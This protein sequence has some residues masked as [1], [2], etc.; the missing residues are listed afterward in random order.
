MKFLAPFCIAAAALLLG[1]CATQEV[2]KVVTVAGGRTERIVLTSNGPAH[3]EDDRIT[4]E[5]T[6][7]MP[8]KA[9]EKLAHVYIIKPHTKHTIV[10]VQI[11]DITQD[12]ET[13]L[14][15]TTTPKITQDNFCIGNSEP[16]TSFPIENLAWV[17]HESV[18]TL[19]YRVK[20]TY[21][22]GKTSNLVSA[23]MVPF[24]VKQL[25]KKEL[26]LK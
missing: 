23:F 11:S 8:V 4:V 26:G 21:D 2:I 14:V 9:T 7:I 6:S 12:P 13:V 10:R 22:D 18:T 20:V 19:I 17:H 25:I 16:L 5:L 24:P 1:A 3:A 15:D